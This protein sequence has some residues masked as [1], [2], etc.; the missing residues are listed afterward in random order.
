MSRKPKDATRK[1]V[2]E[3]LKNHEFLLFLL[4]GFDIVKRYEKEML[5][6]A[7]RTRYKKDFNACLE[8]INEINHQKK[9]QEIVA[10][11]TIIQKYL[12]V[13]DFLMS[14]FNTIA[15][16]LYVKRELEDSKTVFIL[17]STLNPTVP[18]YF[19][20]LAAIDHNLGNYN[21]ALAFAEFAVA[22]DNNNPRT[23]L[24]YAS[25][26][27]DQGN[28]SLAKDEV[29]TVERLFSKEDVNAHDKADMEDLQALKSELVG[30]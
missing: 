14:T 7:E 8:H 24:L 9:P 23:H 6:P 19:T 30:V 10:I 4:K 1:V 2:E 11:D 5:T 26:L 13:S 15:Y 22:L 17:L 29:R 27:L 18:S 12:G 20:A 21:E 25:L 3:K 28:R 16:N